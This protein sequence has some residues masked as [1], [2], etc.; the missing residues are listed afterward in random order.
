MPTSIPHMSWTNGKSIAG[1][2]CCLW[3]QVFSQCHHICISLLEFAHHC[4]MGISFSKIQR[5]NNG[6]N[7]IEPV[8]DAQAINPLCPSQV[9][10][11]HSAWTNWSEWCFCHRTIWKFKIQITNLLQSTSFPFKIQNSKFK[12]CI[13]LF[14]VQPNVF[15]SSLVQCSS[16]AEWAT[17]RQNV[18]SEVVIKRVK[19][20]D[21][22]WLI[23]E[24]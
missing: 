12:C 15:G 2:L 4:M 13:V 10:G 5:W 21:V 11:A 9:W 19:T 18:A 1:S 17:D 22:W 6:H 16:C 8:V 14:D 24:N 3:V 23:R 20:G 7:P